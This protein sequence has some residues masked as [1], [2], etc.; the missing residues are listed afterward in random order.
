[1][2]TSFLIEEHDIKLKQLLSKCS[3]AEVLFLFKTVLFILPAIFP[4]LI[5]D[6]SYKPCYTKLTHTY[7]LK[8]FG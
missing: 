7:L 1:M 8:Q 2:P 4:V 5:K 3:L 6:T